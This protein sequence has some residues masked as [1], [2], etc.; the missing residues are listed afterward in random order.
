MFQIHREGRW[1]KDLN[2]NFGLPCLDC[3]GEFFSLL[4]SLFL[5]K[6]KAQKFPQAF[7]SAMGWSSAILSPASHCQLQPMGSDSTA[8]LPGEEPKET[9]RT[10]GREPLSPGS[11]GNT[12]HCCN[13]LEA[14]CPSLPALMALAVKTLLTK[15]ALTGSSHGSPTARVSGNW[16]EMD[17]TRVCPKTD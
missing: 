12:C 10:A 6:L 16:G 14:Q 15:E 5:C 7:E 11:Q 17:R 9:N 8:I 2:I 4:R 13:W 1:R 3:F